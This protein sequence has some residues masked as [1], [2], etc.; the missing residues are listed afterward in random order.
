MIFSGNQGVFSGGTKPFRSRRRWIA[1]EILEEKPRAVEECHRRSVVIG[2]QR[3]NAS[4]YIGEVLLEKNSCDAETGQS[5][6]QRLK[7]DHAW[8]PGC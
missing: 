3:I 7:A 2:R 4:L 6:D 8:V 5:R 1:G